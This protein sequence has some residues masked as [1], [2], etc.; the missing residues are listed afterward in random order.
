MRLS[1]VLFSVFPRISP[2]RLSQFD[3]VGSVGSNEGQPQMDLSGAV[4]L[5]SVHLQ[6]A[7]GVAAVDASPSAIACAECDEQR[8]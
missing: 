8:Q 6:N 5:V 7:K 1:F 2:I 3:R 4:E